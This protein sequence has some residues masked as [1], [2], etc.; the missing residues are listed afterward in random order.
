MS[1]DETQHGLR[2]TLPNNRY[3]RPR[4]HG[5]V[6]KKQS[7][8]RT[9]DWKKRSENDSARWFKAFSYIF[10]DAIQLI[11]ATRDKGNTIESLYVFSG[12]L[13]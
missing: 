13:V 6:F 1:N 11:D 5:T 10:L 9:L 4:V 2:F 7:M 12:T 8:R 3:E